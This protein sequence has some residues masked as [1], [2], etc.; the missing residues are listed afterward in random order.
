MKEIKTC[1]LRYS[2]Y[3]DLDQQLFDLYDRGWFVIVFREKE[4]KDV[5][6]Y[7]AT[8]TFEVYEG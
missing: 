4:L 3:N 5:K 8:V 1:K 7:E 6:G 2:D